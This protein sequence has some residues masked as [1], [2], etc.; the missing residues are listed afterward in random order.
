MIITLKSSNMEVSLLPIG[1]TIYELKTKD[2]NGELKNII[3]SH[4][5]YSTYTSNNICNLGST[6]GRVAGLVKNASLSIDGNTYELTKNFK[7]SHTLHGGIKNL[8][9]V[10]WK[11]DVSSNANKS[12]CTFTYESS[13]MEEGF[14]AN[15]RLSV[16]YVL[17]KNTLTIYY[18]SIGSQ[19][20]FL[21]LT[22]HTYF[23]LGDDDTI[24]NHSLQIDSDKYM[25]LNNES[26]NINI[27]NVKGTSFNFKSKKLLKNILNKEDNC[28]SSLDDINNA[29]IFNRNN[30]KDYNLML[31]DK[32]SGRNVKI[33]TSYPVCT[34]SYYKN[35]DYSISLLDRKN[36]SYAGICIMPQFIVN[37]IIQNSCGMPIID[38]KNHYSEFIKYIFNNN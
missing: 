15:V 32:E 14:P 1:A 13:H 10:Y 33:K 8:S 31:E 37:N 19:K 18:Y 25:Y 7:G 38:N 16:Q 2:K 4:K 28:I 22:N 6:C 23:N 3:L 5:E 27:K 35:N 36:V 12:I 17:E 24:H 34:L 26:E 9:N 20:T 29:F 11:Y 21:N 30:N